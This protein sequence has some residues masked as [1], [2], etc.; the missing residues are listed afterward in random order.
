MSPRQI[1]AR[2]RWCAHERHLI[3]RGTR[4]QLDPMPAHLRRAWAR[5]SPFASS[6]TTM[7][8]S[9]YSADHVSLGELQLEDLVVLR[10]ELG[11]S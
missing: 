9:W 7:I 3:L 6:P 5:D 10:A 11:R 8:E 1:R 2:Q 4:W